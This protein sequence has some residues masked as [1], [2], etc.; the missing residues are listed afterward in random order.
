MSVKNSLAAGLALIV[1]AWSMQAAAT[2]I[3]LTPAVTNTTVGSNFAVDVVLSGL[4]ASTPS[5]ALT[6]FDLDISYDTSLLNAVGVTFGTGLGGP[7]DGFSGFDLSV[8][9]VVD[10]FAVSFLTQYVDLRALQGDTFTLATL[11]FSALAPGTS[12]LAFVQD[13]NFMVGLINANGQDPINGANPAQCQAR[14]C[15][16]VGGARVVTVPG[17]TVPEPSTLLLLG[18]AG[19]ALAR[20]RRSSKFSR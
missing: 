7:L 17:N 18:I 5:L 19:L 6:D 2:R 10:L 8:P 14:S 1:C 9:E 15:V 4:S 20:A 3:D 12:S 13:V 11:T 16:D